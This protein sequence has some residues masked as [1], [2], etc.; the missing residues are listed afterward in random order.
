[1][2][3]GNHNDQFFS[4]F[5]LCLSH[6]ALDQDDKLLGVVICK[7]EPHREGR[8]RG[9][10]AMLVVLDEHRG[11]GIA[12]TLVRKTINAMIAKNAAEVRSKCSWHLIRV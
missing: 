10:I 8:L 2:F 7:L 5:L 3:H 6:Q 1:M 12:T 9:Y 11:K 4:K